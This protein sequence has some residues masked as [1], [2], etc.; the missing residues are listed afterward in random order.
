MIWETA[1]EAMRLRTIDTILI[2]TEMGGLHAQLNKTNSSFEVQPDLAEQ[3]KESFTVGC[4]G[5]T[6]PKLLRPNF[7][8]VTQLV[9]PPCSSSQAASRAW[10]DDL[11]QAGSYMG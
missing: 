6:L 10:V 8:I 4:C 9:L 1:Q 5:R 3:E 11:R 7:S 2:T